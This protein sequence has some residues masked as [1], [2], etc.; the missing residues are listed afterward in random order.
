MIY[1][2][3]GDVNHMCELTL[4]ISSKSLGL[5]PDPFAYAHGRDQFGQT[6]YVQ[7]RFRKL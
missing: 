2:T 6:I 1:G 5:S 3:K 4:E 7:L